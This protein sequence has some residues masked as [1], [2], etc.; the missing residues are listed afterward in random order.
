MKSYL[1]LAVL[2]LLSGVERNFADTVELNGV[3][4]LFGDKTAFLVLH[5]SG[6]TKSISFILSAGESRFGI[7]VI[8][9]DV[10]GHRAIIEQSGGT[11]IVRLCPAPELTI[12]QA[13]AAGGG[14]PS[15]NGDGLSAEEQSQVEHFLNENEDVQRIREGNPAAQISYVGAPIPSA[16][17]SGSAPGNS[18]AG[19]SDGSSSAGNTGTGGAPDSNSTSNV[20]GSGSSPGSSPGG[21]SGS[22]G[23]VEDYTQQYWYKESL[24]IERNRLATANDVLYNGMDALPRTPLTPTDTPAALIGSDTY[25]S[26]H[27]P[28][29]VAGGSVDD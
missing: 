18:S 10:P 29:F 4:S 1:P 19:P 17:A 12:P 28:G 15:S 22:P 13:L 2:L 26:S 11:Q 7:K 25:F 14:V 20:S 5:Q 23:T 3:A 8:A 21:D 27:I 9:V 16:G 24:A 6:Q